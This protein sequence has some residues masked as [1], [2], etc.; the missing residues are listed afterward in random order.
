MK[1]IQTFCWIIAWI[2]IAL[3]TAPAYPSDNS[4]AIISLAID[5]QTPT[6]L[7]AGTF[8]RGVFKSTD[9]GAN[10]T[11]T[12][13]TNTAVGFLAVAPTTPTTLYAGTY[14]DGWLKSTDEGLTWDAAG[15]DTAWYDWY[16]TGY[17][18]GQT[19]VMAPLVIDPVTPSTVYAVTPSGVFKSTDSGDSWTPTALMNDRL[20]YTIPYDFPAVATIQTL[21]FA[22]STDPT[23]PATLYAGVTYVMSDAFETYVWGEMVRTT[24]DDS[25]N[26]WWIGP[27]GDEWSALYWAAPGLAIAPASPTA[28]ATVYTTSGVSYEHPG[29]DWFF[30]VSWWTGDDERHPSGYSEL[31]DT[32]ASISLLVIDPQD[33]ATIY[34]ATTSG[35]HKS[36]DE[37]ASWSP[38]NSGLTD[39]LQ[40]YGVGTNVWAL[41]IDPVTPATLYAGTDLGVF[42]STD[43]GANWSPTGLFQLSPLSSV[44]LAPERVVGGNTSTGTVTLTV[45]AP[46]GGITV[47][48]SSNSTAHATVPA[49]VTVPSG[50][51]DATFMVSTSPLDTGSRS[52]EISATLDGVTR[53]A[54][55]T[56]IAPP[57][58]GSLNLSPNGVIG[59]TTSNGRVNLNSPA[60]ED[61]AT[62][63]LS[64][65]DP[66]VATV[67]L[68]VTVAAGDTGVNFM[69]T[70][71]SVPAPTTVTLSGTY[72]GVTR[73]A[74]L[75]VAPTATLSSLNLPVVTSWIG[76]TT[77]AGNVD[78]N[79]AAPTGGAVITLSSSNPAV[80]SVPASVTV[81]AGASHQALTVSTRAVA[82]PT[83][84]TISGAYGGVTKSAMFTIIPPSLSSLSLDATSVS[85][86]STSAGG[87]GLN[88]KAPEGG[89]TVILSSSNPAA[90]AVPSSVTV[91]AGAWSAS[92]TVLTNAVTTATTVTISG[93]YGGVMRSAM[94]TVTP[95][96]AVLS[97]V[98][99]DPDSVTGGNGATKTITL[100]AA[101]P[102]GGAIVMLSSSNLAVA[103]VPASVIVAA[104]ASSANFTISTSSVTVS[105]AVTISATLDGITKSAVLTVDPANPP[106]TA[107]PDTSIT[108]A[109]DS[110]GAL[111]PNGGATLSNVAILSFTGT[112]N[113]AIAG[114]ECRLDG[115][116][117]TPCTSPVT[118]SGLAVG[119]HSFGVRTF[120]T[121]GN[122]DSSPATYAWSVDAP[123]DTEITSAVDGRGK[124]IPPN[125]GTT[126]SKVM[127]FSF[128][129]TDNLSV[130][131]FEC[132]LDGASFKPCS[133][134]ITLSVSRGTHT[135]QVQAMDNNG[136]RDATPA[137]FTW[138]RR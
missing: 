98:S 40:A 9:G 33:P 15:L 133:S 82:A 37:G 88:G 31:T 96:P 134:P 18:T 118:H 17:D 65:T 131:G 89:A 86:G 27:T 48:L 20:G 126:R 120:D 14:G 73:S 32:S 132:R 12:G 30:D 102:A 124:A 45:A 109:V 51:T 8:D 23:T 29:P 116:D 76:G 7:Y 112:D 46:E 84:V 6:T 57:I 87:V 137:T 24:D 93:A 90:A 92:F 114:F 138:T 71:N 78:L 106:D 119:G 50:S 81:A 54:M 21:A 43:G 111:V 63:A 49:G 136:F 125:A 47:S 68:N 56:V 36:T 100:S 52:V 55:L 38:V 83:T 19:P 22:P 61:G 66:A 105:T 94:L 39:T 13:L 79:V 99:F 26:V 129:G 64:S 2:I 35:I 121:S 122:R 113:V 130:V 25:G 67:P 110:N 60:L 11:S 1:R 80:A 3:G 115:G 107:T 128:T 41:V 104:G 58:L 91:P 53:E 97:S 72:G 95:P 101:A 117:F 103:T 70:T 4:T 16:Y 75:S 34:A 108:S 74:V 85:V 77:F 28:P 62:V 135:F 69:V 5:P 44:T 127:T 123:P 42:K 59:G 10:W